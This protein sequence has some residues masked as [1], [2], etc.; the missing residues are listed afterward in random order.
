MATYDYRCKNCDYEKQ[1]SHSMKES[2]EIKCEECDHLMFKMV[3]KKINFVLAGTNWSGKNAKEK[4]FR[5]KRRQE[6]G[7]RMASSHDIPQ[8][9]PNYKGEICESWDQ[10]KKLAKDDGVDVNRYEKQVENLKKQ[11]V[12]T[13]IKK[14]KLLKGEA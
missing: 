10:A 5:M 9:Q 2:P 12:E 7:K 1:V 13:K 4:S 3:P 14:E 11:E 8:I 6:M